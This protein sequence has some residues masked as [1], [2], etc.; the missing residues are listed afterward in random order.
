MEVWLWLSEPVRD[1]HS[2]G[3]KFPTWSVWDGS[4]NAVKLA[5]GGAAVIGSGEFRDIHESLG[6]GQEPGASVAYFCKASS[7][8]RQG[9]RR[10]VV[11]VVLRPRSGM[12][13]D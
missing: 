3:L 9:Y 11:D 8:W 4:S 5:A 6:C 1:S 7:D 10:R 2:A 13:L 12:Q